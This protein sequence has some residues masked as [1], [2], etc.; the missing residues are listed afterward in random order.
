MNRNEI[1]NIKSIT[2]WAKHLA[3]QCQ[4]SFSRLIPL[5]DNEIE[6]LNRLFDYGEIEPSLICDDE[7]LI[8][9]IKMHPALKWSIKTRLHNKKTI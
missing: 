7:N 1:N 2:A 9:N 6:F 3:E 8:E 4:K 5:K